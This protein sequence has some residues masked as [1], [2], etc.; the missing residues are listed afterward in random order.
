MEQKRIDRISA[1]TRISRTRDLTEAE[2]AE[3]EELRSEYRAAVRASLEGHLE[4]TYLVDD[5][6]TQRKLGKTGPS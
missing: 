2:Q 5:K 4:N 1:L 3:R 6:G